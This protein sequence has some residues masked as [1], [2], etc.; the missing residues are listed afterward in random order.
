MSYKTLESQAYAVMYTKDRVEI[1][2]TEEEYEGTL[3][4]MANPEVKATASILDDGTV[5]ALSNI[6]RIEVL[7]HRIPEEKRLYSP[8]IESNPSVSSNSNGWNKAKETML[9]KYPF[10]KGAHE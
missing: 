5:V 7:N 6:A 10:L 3:G 1:F 4:L 8:E 2:L 9:K